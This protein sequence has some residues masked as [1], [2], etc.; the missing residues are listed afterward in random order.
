[1][2]KRNEREAETL[3]ALYCRQYEKDIRAVAR[4]V[5][6][7]LGISESF[8]EDAVQ[9]TKL[10][11]LRSGE[12]VPG[13]PP[14]RTRAY[15]LA[16]AEHIS[17]RIFEKEHP[18]KRTDLT[19]EALE[20]I[21]TTED[22]TAELFDRMEYKEVVA[23]LRELP[24]GVRAAV[25]LYYGEGL[26]APRIAAMTGESVNTVYTRVRRGLRQLRKKMGVT[27]GVSGNK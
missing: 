15:V 8:I 4:K 2:T 24:S 14:E 19:D 13:E 3:P 12:N 9:E 21:P 27:E 5:F 20:G 25:Y 22:F 17:L 1:M 18:D 16:M 23:A 7:R 11:I 26:S 10:A 6:R